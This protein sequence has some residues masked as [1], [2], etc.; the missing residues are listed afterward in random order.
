MAQVNI[1]LNESS[2]KTLNKVRVIGAINNIQ[3]NNKET[4]INKCLDWFETLITSLGDES[5]ENILNLK[6]SF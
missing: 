6:K 4:Q 2:E 3:L 5:I 1:K